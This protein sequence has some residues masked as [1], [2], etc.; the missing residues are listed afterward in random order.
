M[1]LGD[2][3]RFNSVVRDLHDPTAIGIIVDTTPNGRVYTKEYVTVYWL[4]M[5]EQHEELIRELE[6]ISEAR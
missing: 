5:N 4:D 3:V 2:M 6:V 1:K